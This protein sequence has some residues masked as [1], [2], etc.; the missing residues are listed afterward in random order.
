MVRPRYS[1]ELA[2]PALPGHLFQLHI[3]N[4]SAQ[5]RA[6]PGEGVRYA[7]ED[8]AAAIIRPIGFKLASV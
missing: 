7:N 2:E 6:A 4:L 5:G 8:E 1:P 3:C